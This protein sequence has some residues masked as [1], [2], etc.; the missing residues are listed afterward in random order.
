MRLA[1]HRPGEDGQGAQR[2]NHKCMVDG[3][4]CRMD[5]SRVDS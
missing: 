3:Y 5:F 2:A 1:K 4:P